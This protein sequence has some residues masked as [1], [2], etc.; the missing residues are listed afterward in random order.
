MT[1]WHK[2]QEGESHTQAVDRDKKEQQ[3]NKETPTKPG[4][5]VKG[6]KQSVAPVTAAEEC[7]NEMADRIARYATD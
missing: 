3:G 7:K 1:S 5:G 6:G 2:K 4:R